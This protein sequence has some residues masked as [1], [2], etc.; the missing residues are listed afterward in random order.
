L[1]AKIEGGDYMT[2]KLK[3]AAAFRKELIMRGYSFNEFARVAGISGPYVAQ[4]ANG[5]RNPSAKVAK[6]ISNALNVEFD[7]IFFVDDACK[8]YQTA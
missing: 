2:I 5:T 7:D 3:D 1:Q 6:K 8:S 4:I